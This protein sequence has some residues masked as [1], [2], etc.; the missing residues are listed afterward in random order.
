[1]SALP[2]TTEP[3]FHVRL[4]GRLIVSRCAECGLVVAASPFEY[5]LQYAER[6]HQCPVYLNYY[7]P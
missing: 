6:L 2:Q 1:M 5:V 3:F 4:G 7:N